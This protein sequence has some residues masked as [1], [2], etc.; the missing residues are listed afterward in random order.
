MS[1]HQSKYDQVTNRIIAELEEGVAPWVKP[2]STGSSVAMPCNAATGRAYS[3]INVL[4]LWD[5]A[6]RAAYP[7]PRWLTFR[8]VQEHRGYVRKGERGAR[9]FFVKSIAQDEDEEQHRKRRSLLRAYTV[10]NV[11]QCEEL[12][13]RFY[14]VPAE[15]PAEEQRQAMEQFLTAVG[16]TVRFGGDRAFYSPSAD[17]IVLPAFAAFES[18]GHFYAT[19]LHEHMHWSGSEKRL[20][21]EFGKRFGDRAYAAD[22]LVAELGAAFLCARIGIEGKLRHAEY[23]GSWIELLKD[24]PRAIFTAASKASQAADFLSSFSEVNHNDDT[25]E[26]E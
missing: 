17:V 16:A 3:G 9:V 10:F 11:A 4:T 23:I 1:E 5:A 13:A 21:R 20:A 14:D 6:M 12:P 15:R 26:A 18:A 24:D 22:E 2:W 8:Q 19:S 25:G 7:V